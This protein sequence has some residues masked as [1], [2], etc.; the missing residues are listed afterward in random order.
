MGLLNTTV[1][2]ATAEDETTSSPLNSGNAFRIDGGQT[3]FN[4]IA[5]NSYA[6]DAKLS[7]LKLNRSFMNSIADGDSRERVYDNGLDSIG[8][9]TYTCLYDDDSNDKNPASFFRKMRAGGKQ[10]KIVEYPSSSSTAKK[11]TGTYIVT[12]VETSKEGGGQ[13]MLE[14]TLAFDGETLTDARA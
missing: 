7:P 9:R 12:S 6:R 1:F 10:V 5:A 3:A 4:S 8:E 11:F 2:R 13:Q 14:V